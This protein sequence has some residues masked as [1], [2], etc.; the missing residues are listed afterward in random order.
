MEKSTNPEKSGVIAPVPGT[1]VEH[2]GCKDAANYTDN[3][4]AGKSVHSFIFQG[5]SLTKGCVP[6]QQS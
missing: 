4:T 5:S 1:R 6:I 2:I 3:V